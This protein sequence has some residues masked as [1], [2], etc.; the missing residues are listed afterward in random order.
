MK[1]ILLI[2][3][4]LFILAVSACASA[5]VATG[6]G[7]GMGEVT[8]TL[9][10]EDGKIIEA[11]VDTSNET[12]GF[13]KDKAEQF[14]E[15][16]LQ[17]QGADF[18][19]IAGC[20]ITSGAVKTALE[21]ALSS[22]ENASVASLTPGT[23]VGTAY[24]A[25]STIRM[26]VQVSEDSI[27]N[28]WP[29]E[30]H[31]T[32]VI[33]EIAVQTVADEIVAAQ[34]LS[35]DA[36]TGATLSSNGARKAVADALEQA[37]AN[38]ADWYRP[39]AKETTP[40]EDVTVDV[41][42]VGGGTAGLTAALAAKTNTTFD[43]TDS[44]LNVMVIEHNGFAG[45]DLAFCGGIV[46][47]YQNTVFNEASGVSNDYESFRD[48]FLRLRPLRAPYLRE[49]VA[50]VVFEKTG[51]VLSGL[52]DRGFYLSVQ[53]MKM[54]SLADET[55]P[56]G[57]LPYT[58]AITADPNTMVRSLDP[59]YYSQ[60]GSPMMAHSLANLTKDAGVD[61]QYNTT[62]T[63]LLVENGVCTGVT[64]KDTSGEYSIHAKKVILCTGYSNFDDESVE[65]FYP[66]LKGVSRFTSAGNNSD[67]QKWIHAM[68]GEVSSEQ[69]GSSFFFGYQSV[70]GNSG[71]EGALYG[72]IGTVWVDKHGNRYLDES[73][74]TSALNLNHTALDLLKLD[75]ACTYMI[76]DSTNE[77][78][79]FFYDLN[80]QGIAWQGDTIAELAE[81]A[82]IDAA[83]LE[84]TLE[85]YNADSQADGDTVFGTPKDKMSPVLEAPFY[86][87]K[88]NVVCTS[89]GA[90]LY[91]DDDLTVLMSADGSRIENLY[92]AGGCAGNAF[93]N[94]PSHGMHVIS[95][96]TSGSYAGDCARDA[97]LLQGE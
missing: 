1:K 36:L 27:L 30:N 3:V 71:A 68:G 86:A 58:I 48:T 31:D 14:E 74:D 70:L 11:T 37:G 91:V 52:M 79:K 25:K 60:F 28:I 76:F 43:Y 96:L 2:A 53:D 8:V 18:D 42:V 89:G 90:S 85:R 10:I 24:G 54:S 5:E 64:A 6:K 95:S 93:I 17:A 55:L 22:G 65:L 72:S 19:A 69:S 21:Q 83:G 49:N 15:L 38:I 57:K 4:L 45:G 62:A 23:Y 35:V 63:G 81:Q 32:A 82:G 94:T 78:V 50:K 20:T 80:G 46:A 84:A 16:I 61:I 75:G 87:V 13:G 33:S 51:P 12:P 26:A 97:L 47:A 40:H 29:L 44:G 7:F 56:E 88:L 77:G 73:G 59:G 39:I 67:A 41:L 92:A 34:S 9:N 66:E